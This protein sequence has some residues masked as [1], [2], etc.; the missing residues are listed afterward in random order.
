MKKILFQYALLSGGLVDVYLLHAGQSKG[1]MLVLQ[2][3]SPTPGYSN[4]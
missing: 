2:W 4:M 1:C 3:P